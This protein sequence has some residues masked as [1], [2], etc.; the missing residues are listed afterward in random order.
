MR[1][2]TCI[3]WCF[4]CCVLSSCY[5]N[6]SLVYLQDKD[7]SERNST[8]MESKK[9]PYRL[10]PFDILAVQ[11]KSPVEQRESSGGVGFTS[12][13]NSMFVTPGNLYLDG[14]S[15]DANGKITLPVLGQI[16][17]KGLTLEEAQSAIQV[18]ANKYLNNSVVT[19]KLV[20][21]KITVLGEVKNPGYYF[22][23]NNQATVLEAL[24]M[25]GD[26]TNFGNRKNIK[27][28]RQ[29]SAGSEVNLLDL[30]NANL[31]TSDLFFLQPGDVLYVEPLR[32]RSRRSNLDLLSVLFSAMTTTVLVLSYM[33]NQ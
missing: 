12:P 25:A 32:A 22:V 27:L 1:V 19:L 23:Y 15:V 28:I 26:L 7:F 6:K 13:Q 11:I 14:Y 33:N 31:L 10:Q 9:S 30:T 18:Q 29:V 20:S 2:L 17:V 5:Y 4:C 24:G 16:M 8:L 3:L 21:F